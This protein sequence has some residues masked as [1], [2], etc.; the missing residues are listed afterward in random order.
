MLARV[1]DFFIGK[2]VTH[3]VVEV[4][5]EDSTALVFHTYS[6]FRQLAQNLNALRFFPPAREIRRVFRRL[7]LDEPDAVI[8]R[9][10]MTELDEWL[11]VVFPKKQGASEMQAFL[12]SARVQS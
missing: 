7:W 5:N 9:E 8:C 3:Y 6:E 2:K 11:Q 10:R 4:Q 1:V 12:H